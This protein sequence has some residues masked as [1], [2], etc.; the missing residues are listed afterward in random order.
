MIKYRLR[1]EVNN[2]EYKRDSKINSIIDDNTTP[3]LIEE[4]TPFTLPEKFDYV[5]IDDV[6]YQVTKL[7]NKIYKKNGVQY[8]ETVAIL[9]RDKYANYNNLASLYA[10]PKTPVVTKKY[11]DDPNDFDI[12]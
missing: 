7:K 4:D 5:D 3:D 11:V 8:F 2:K 1:F 9:S 10:P 6:E 12:L